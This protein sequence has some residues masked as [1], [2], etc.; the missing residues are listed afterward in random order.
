MLD[1]LPAGWAEAHVILTAANSEQADRAALVL[2]PLAPG[3]SGRTFRLS[4]Y[5]SGRGGPSP[6]V[7]LRAL[8]RLEAEGVD[9]RLSLPETA[10]Y[11]V[12]PPREQ[13][14]PTGLLGESWNELVA[15]LPEDWSD[16][17]LE[18]EL[19]SSDEIDRAALLLGPVNPLLHEGARPAFRF[20]SARRSGYGAAAEMTHR[21]LTRLDEQ[22]IG[23]RL[24]LLRVFSDTAPVLTQGPVWRE[25]GRAI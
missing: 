13:G 16:L 24:R 21:C 19:A 22:H 12:A 6:A 23:G 9:A 2:A 4:V 15:R 7:V 10:A 20:R 14:P 25:G 11:A 17:Y 18:L 1:E 5:G 3:R 8:G